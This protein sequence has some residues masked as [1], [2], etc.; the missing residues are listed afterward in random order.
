MAAILPRGDRVFIAGRKEVTVTIRFRYNYH[1]MWGRWINLILIAATVLALLMAALSAVR[2]TVVSVP[3]GMRTRVAFHSGYGNAT[4][5]VNHAQ[6]QPTIS[7]QYFIKTP[8]AMTAHN[9]RQLAKGLPIENFDELRA[10]AARS[11]SDALPD[12]S[13][14][15]S[16]SFT[17]PWWFIISALAAYP[18]HRLIRHV[19]TPRCRNCK[20]PLTGVLDEECP[21]CAYPIPPATRR[22]IEKLAR[23]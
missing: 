8:Q 20:Q 15:R 6:R 14:R 13:Q 18:I 7:L 22:R 1:P 10:F 23:Q 19:R 21:Q 11:T 17:L 9:E 12:G 5:S 16:W 2:L 4:L 3:L